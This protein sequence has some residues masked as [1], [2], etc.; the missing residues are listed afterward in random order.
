M[1]LHSLL[2]K[3]ASF[4]SSVEY[5]NLVASIGLEVASTEVKDILWT[6]ECHQYPRLLHWPLQRDL[7]HAS[8]NPHPLEYCRDKYEE[9]LCT[10]ADPQEMLHVILVK[11]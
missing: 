7:N 5:C 1:V 2:P 4:L 10:W 6:C 9:D 3:G 11:L 8:I